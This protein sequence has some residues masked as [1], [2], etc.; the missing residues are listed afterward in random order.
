M[1]AAEA[2]MEVR[3]MAQA[4]QEA[5]A[6]RATPAQPGRLILVAVEA[7]AE[8]DNLAALAVLA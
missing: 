8:A 7:A 1:Q 4:V 5:A 3:L 2:D 6:L